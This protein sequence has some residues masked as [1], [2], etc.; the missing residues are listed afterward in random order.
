MTNEV[1]WN[2]VRENLCFLRTDGLSFR[3]AFDYEVS[4]YVSTGTESFS[5]RSAAGA[6]ILGFSHTGSGQA[7]HDKKSTR[8]SR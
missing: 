3:D 6:E 8:V 2:A 5:K 1:N 7:A 4:R